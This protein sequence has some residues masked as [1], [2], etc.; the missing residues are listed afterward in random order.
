MKKL[1][2]PLLIISII[3][4]M[5]VFYSC[6][7]LIMPP[8]LEDNP[9]DP[10]GDNF[11]PEPVTGVSV[12]PET[13]T[14]IVDT[15]AQITGTVIPLW[16]SNRTIS[17]TTSADSIATVTASGLVTAI[18]P[19]S[20]TITAESEDGGYTGVCSIT[21]IMDPS[22]ITVESVD[23]NKDTTSILVN[24]TEQ[25]AA[26][27]SPSNAANQDIS[28]SS[29]NPSVATVSSTGLVTG[30]SVGTAIITVTTA[31]GNFQDICTV[32]IQTESIPVES[33]SLDFDTA[34]VFVDETQQLTASIF[35]IG[36][37][38][39]NL[40][41]ASETESIASVNSSGLVTGVAVGSA[42]ITATTV[43]GGK[44]ASCT[45]T[46]SIQSSSIEL[47]YTAITLA[48]NETRQLIET[49]L[50]VETTDKS[51]IWSSDNENTATVNQDGLV[52]AVA[53]GAA[54]ITVTTVDSEKFATCMVT[55]TIPVTSVALDLET[56]S[57]V[58]GDMENLSATVNPVN[59][60]VDTVSWESDTP[61]VANVDSNGLVT[62]Y[63]A[64]TAIITVTTDDGGEIDTCTVTVT[65]AT[66]AVTGVDLTPSTLQTIGVGGQIQFTPTITPNDA[67][68]QNVT[69]SSANTAIAS[70][71]G[72][73]LVTGVAGGTVN[74][75]V[76]TVDG[77]KTDSCEVTVD[78][79][80]VTS[81]L[82]NKDSETLYIAEQDQLTATVLPDTATDQTVTWTTTNA[83][84]ASVTTAGLVTA[85]AEGNATIIVTTNDGSYTDTYDVTVNSIAVTSVGLNKSS[86]TIYSGFNERLLAEIIPSNASNKNVTWMTTNSS[87]ATVTSDGVVNAVSTGNTSITVTTQD[88]NLND[89][90]TVTVSDPSFV[91]GNKITYYVEECIFDMVYLEGGIT[92]FTGTDDLGGQETVAASYWVADTEVTYELWYQVHT[93]AL[94]NGYIFDSDNGIEGHDGIQDAA[95]TAAAQEPVTKVD[96]RNAV[97]WCNA[98]TEYYNAQNNTSMVCVYKDSGVPIRNSTDTSLIDNVV[99][100]TDAGG[101]RLLDHPE[102]ELAARYR[103]DANSDNDIMDPDE[104]YPGNYAS[105]ATDS[106]SNSTA[107]QAVAW[108]SSGGGSITHD[109]KTKASNALG[110]YDMS[111]N[112]NEWV[113]YVKDSDERGRCGGAFNTTNTAIQVGYLGS[114]WVY[115]NYNYNG[116][117]FGRSAY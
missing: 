64:G 96:F 91:T 68:N 95:P 72:T 93:W 1:I 79:T 35:P 61:A 12:S 32:E 29:G 73:G 107:T 65:L 23:L 103:D 2:I 26:T 92:F 41:W 82:L 44:T 55:V 27:V 97:V 117:R 42:V 28:W 30:V 90:C 24:G 7:L 59:A 105:G 40:T 69:W 114:G 75:T 111:G 16:A 39:Q 37:T 18:S 78:D 33:V 10:E 36:A 70:V 108:Y 17:W 100:D 109:V 14:M 87:V 80:I 54:E 112:V 94:S 66:I 102:W 25:L 89:S 88:G 57:L 22:T 58:V 101:F 52:T 74:I 53:A 15:N 99:P 8:D 76:M 110:L 43:D 83:L 67:T 38:N 85:V 9:L 56:L 60:T 62:A 116:F 49:V 104:Y 81:V 115:N 4:G 6:N 77:T 13:L 113:L 46:V 47:D 98:L 5:V 48:P 34:S 71:D 11:I 86:T 20:A 31:D 84:I 21:V 63:N 45:V 106:I 51:V 3:L 19:G 50:P